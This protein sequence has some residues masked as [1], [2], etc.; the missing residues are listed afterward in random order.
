M[1]HP[2][3]SVLGQTNTNT[4]EEGGMSGGLRLIWIVDKAADRLMQAN[5]LAK[6]QS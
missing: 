2:H 5:G 4:T 1:A 3:R 6:G